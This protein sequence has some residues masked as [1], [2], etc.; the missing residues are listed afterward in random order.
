MQGFEGTHQS[1]VV[2][3]TVDIRSNV[4]PSCQATGNL[5][6]EPPIAQSMDEI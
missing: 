1:L 4:C 6:S 3:L 5:L 2:G